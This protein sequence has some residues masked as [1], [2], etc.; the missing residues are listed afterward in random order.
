MNGFK[1]KTDANFIL[2]IPI[3]L[4]PCEIIYGYTNDWMSEKTVQAVLMEYMY[5]RKELLS[6]EEEV[7]YQ[8]VNANPWLVMD[9]LE[10]IRNLCDSQQKINCDR[11]WMFLA[12]KW[13]YD[14]IPEIENPLEHL[15]MMIADFNYPPHLIQYMYFFPSPERIDIIKELSLFLKG[16]LLYFESQEDRLVGL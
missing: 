8:D 6:L 5:Q 10:G 16:E 2:G 14:H 3:V 7:V 11:V 12:L 4:T 9:A 13:F 1:W 15:A